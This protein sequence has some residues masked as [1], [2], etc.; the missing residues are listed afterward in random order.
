LIRERSERINTVEGP[1][2]CFEAQKQVSPRAV[3]LASQSNALVG[4]TAFEK[5]ESL[6]PP[7]LPLLG[8]ASAA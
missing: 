2:V 8:I 6:S 7:P 5:N 1:A 4:M 3:G